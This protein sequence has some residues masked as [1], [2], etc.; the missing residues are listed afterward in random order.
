MKMNYDS[1]SQFWIASAATAAVCFLMPRPLRVLAPVAIGYMLYRNGT[2]VFP[3]ADQEHDAAQEQCWCPT[4]EYSECCAQ[5]VVDES[6]QES[7]PASDPPSFS[8]GTAAPAVHP[9]V[10]MNQ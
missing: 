2:D 6:S 3:W 8:P 7:F 4:E 10:E 9:S 5:D 1:A